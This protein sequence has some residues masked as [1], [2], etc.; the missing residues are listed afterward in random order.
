MTNRYQVEYDVGQWTFGS[1]QVW[2]SRD[3][4]VLHTCKSVSKSYLHDPVGQWNE[5]RSLQELQHPHVTSLVDVTEDATNVYLL[6]EHCPGGDVQEWLERLDSE[7]NWCEERTVSEYVRHALL[8]LSHCHAARLYHHDL[9][10]SCLGLTS[11]LPDAE[12]KVSDFGFARIIDPGHR[13]AQR[14]PSPFHS[15][16]ILCGR[17]VGSPGA[18]DMWSIGA[19]THCLLVGRPPYCNPMEE[20]RLSAQDL[21]HRMRVPPRFSEEEGWDERSDSS[22][23]F[24]RYLLRSAGDRPTAAQALHHPWLKG[25][26]GIPRWQMGSAGADAMQ[27]HQ[28]KSLCYLVAVLLV[29]VAVPNRDFE[30]LRS[31]FKAVDVDADG[32]ATRAA[33][34]NV[35][36]GRGITAEAAAMAIAIADVPRTDVLDLCGA[37][38]ADLIAREFLAPGPGRHT[39]DGAAELA[40]KMLQRFFQAFSDRQQ[41]AV[42]AAGVRA[43]LRTSTARSVEL[44]A[45]V[46]YD[47]IIDCFPEDSTVDAPTLTAVLSGSGGQGTPLELAGESSLERHGTDGC[48]V[49]CSDGVGVVFG[50]DFVNILYRLARGRGGC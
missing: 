18:P 21:A 44:H 32:Y 26:L 16:E 13:I 10:L 28:V 8:A 22:R 4:G 46:R 47:E 3:T 14:S 23:D 42:T 36:R 1:V 34:A 9:R 39:P 20:G 45:G 35:L 11:R 24:V 19:L 33:L 2:K 40:P 30:E 50:L 41:P 27:E 15:P 25:T 48:T 49:S 29:P 12:V 38:V 37:S 31:A 7:T 17:E 5:L 43:R 6:L